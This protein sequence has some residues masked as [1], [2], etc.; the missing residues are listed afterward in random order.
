MCRRGRYRIDTETFESWR[1]EGSRSDQGVERN[2]TEAEKGGDFTRSSG[3]SVS[4]L[5]WERAP[6][7]G[8]RGWEISTLLGATFRP[9]KEFGSDGRVLREEDG[10]HMEA[11]KDHEGW[12]V[13]MH[14]AS[15]ILTNYIGRRDLGRKLYDGELCPSNKSAHSCATKT[16]MLS[17]RRESCKC[18]PYHAGYPST[19]EITNNRHPCVLPF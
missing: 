4:G 13:Y 14:N 2:P 18:Q 8:R 11:N 6:E 19:H 7:G 10:W 1:N 17:S 15:V 5:V 12:M 9:L 16:A 3:L